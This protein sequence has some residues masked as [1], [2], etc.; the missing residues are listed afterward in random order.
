[1]GGIYLAFAGEYTGDLGSYRY[2]ATEYISVFSRNRVTTANAW[3]SSYHGV[4][5]VEVS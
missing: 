5:Y 3:R 4:R 1:M 2:R